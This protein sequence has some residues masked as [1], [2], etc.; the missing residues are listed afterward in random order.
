[1]RGLAKYPPVREGVTYVTP[2]YYWPRFWSPRE[3]APEMSHKIDL[4]NKSHNAP[5]PYPQR[6][7]HV[8]YGTGALWYVWDWFIPETYHAVQVTGTHFNIVVIIKCSPTKLSNAESVSIPWRHY[9]IVLEVISCKPTISYCSSLL[10]LLIYQI[11]NTLF[12]M[13]GLHQSGV[14]YRLDSDLKDGLRQDNC[15]QLV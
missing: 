4:I 6:T 2:F 10:V 15:S 5:V 12:C 13:F 1:M 11:I 14:H 7:I 9:E 3:R 8:S